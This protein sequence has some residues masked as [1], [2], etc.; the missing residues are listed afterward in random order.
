[1]PKITRTFRV[2]SNLLEKL[3]IQAAKNGQ[4]ENSLVASLIENYLKFGAWAEVM[5]TIM[6]RK[7]HLVSFLK[8][9]PEAKIAAMGRELG[10]EVTRASVRFMY[11]D[12]TP[13]TFLD[14]IEAQSKYM[15]WGAYSTS[16]RNHA[17]YTP[18][19]RCPACTMT[20]LTIASTWTDVAV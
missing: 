3:K 17:C 1:M 16:D 7:E 19:G 2:E 18:R 8:P 12:F 9:L 5:P 14:I 20:M 15:R 10:K 6:L 4:S 11:P 13:Q